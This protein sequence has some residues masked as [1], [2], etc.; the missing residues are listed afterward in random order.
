MGL[1]L[2]LDLFN[3]RDVSYKQADSKSSSV[4]KLTQIICEQD[5][6]F[7][8]STFKKYNLSPRSQFGI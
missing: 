4:H 2:R 5:Y 8:Y 3:L 6:S 1:R 7:N